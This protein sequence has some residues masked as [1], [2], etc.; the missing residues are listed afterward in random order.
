MHRLGETEA[1]APDTTK[2]DEKK[3]VATNLAQKDFTGHVRPCRRMVQPLP[4]R[5][6]APCTAAHRLK[7]DAGGC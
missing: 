5:S 1:V 2:L 4:S 6:Y 3:I 7:I